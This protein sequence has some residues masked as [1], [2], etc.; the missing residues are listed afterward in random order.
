MVVQAE[1]FKREL[2]EASNGLNILWP[3]IS[4][5]SM[6]QLQVGTSFT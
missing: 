4:L 3:I 2:H 5:S 1:M 6:F